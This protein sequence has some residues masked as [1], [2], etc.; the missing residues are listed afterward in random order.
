M[1][2]TPPTRP[3]RNGQPVIEHW[4]GRTTSI[5]G[6]AHRAD[7]AEDHKIGDEQGQ[8]DTGRDKPTPP[9]TIRHGRV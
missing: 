3:H 2:R 8:N 9:A 6:P 4:W 5:E 1:D 7:R